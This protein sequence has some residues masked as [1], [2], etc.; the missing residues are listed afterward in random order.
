MHD[1]K[2]P[3]AAA[4]PNVQLFFT[5]RSACDGHTDFL[6]LEFVDLFCLPCLPAMQIAKLK[7]AQVKA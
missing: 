5:A 2:E 6:K 7:D 4:Q 3:A 1:D